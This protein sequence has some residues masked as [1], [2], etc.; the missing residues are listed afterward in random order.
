M[1]FFLGDNYEY[2]GFLF[3]IKTTA[4]CADWRNLRTATHVGIET[5]DNSVVIST[6]KISKSPSKFD[7]KTSDE[8]IIRQAEK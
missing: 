6:P 7:A 5:F 4:G 2:S 3:D 8:M 1:L